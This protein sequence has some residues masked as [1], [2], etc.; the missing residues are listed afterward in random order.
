MELLLIFGM[1]M[2]EILTLAT[3]LVSLVVSIIWINVKLSEL[4]N[5]VKLIENNLVRDESLVVETAKI[6]RETTMETAKLLSETTINTAKLLKET[7]EKINQFEINKLN[8][9][10]NK[11]DAMIETINEIQINCA[12]NH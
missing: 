10:D 5:K 2:E 1:N 11:I 4:S 6:L 9:M 12:K 3:L 7:T 8:K